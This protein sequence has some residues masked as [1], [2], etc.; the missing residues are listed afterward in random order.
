MLPK[1]EQRR[2]DEIER[3]LRDDDPRFA[4][5]VT[6]DHARRH[7]TIVGGVGFLLGLAAM[8]IGAVAAQALL[9]VGVII[10]LAGFLAMVATPGGSSADPGGEF[11]A[12][13]SAGPEQK[14]GK[15]R[16]AVLYAPAICDDCEAVFASGLVIPER[17]GEPTS[18]RRS[19]GPCPRCGG[20]GHIPEWVHR[21][22]T[23]A[24]DARRRAS[25]EQISALT[26]ALRHHLDEPPPADRHAPR[27]DP[28]TELI[29]PWHTVAFELRHSP[30]EQRRAQLTLLLW[31]LEN[32]TASPQGP[33]RSVSSGNGRPA[34][35]APTATTRA[36][37]SRQRIAATAPAAPFRHRTRRRV[38]WRQAQLCNGS[39]PP[40]R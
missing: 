40:S 29:G 21:F 16:F 4:S 3:A 11:W 7:H 17:L 27:P 8:I 15:E 28:T 19:A 14:C 13:R 12:C 10:S 26:A 24:V 35:G 34:H 2:L 5:T 37:Q 1:D 18:Y 6:F 20:R 36:P 23:T 33:I 39:R 30:T 22:H 25:P 9:A 31:M 38:H 32:P